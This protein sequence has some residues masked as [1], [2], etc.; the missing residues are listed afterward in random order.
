MALG[1]AT[2]AAGG[3]VAYFV[4]KG[5]SDAKKAKA[6]KAKAKALEPEPEPDDNGDEP[7]PQ[8]GDAGGNYRLAVIQDGQ[9]VGSSCG[10][11]TYFSPVEGESPQYDGYCGYWRTRVGSLYVCDEYQ[12]SFEADVPEILWGDPEA[13][14]DWY[15]PDAWIV[16]IA[17]PTFNEIIEAAVNDGQD[18][19]SLD[20]AIMTNIILDES[21]PANC[22]IPG[23]PDGDFRELQSNIPGQADYFENEAILGLYWHVNEGVEFAIAELQENGTAVFFPLS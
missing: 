21:M 8:P 17:R 9:I 23:A 6:K 13:C 7:E 5:I 22:P 14:D 10:S 11:C 1:L 2:L 3:A 19:G 4:T 20:T 15:L 12:T 18:L 16:E